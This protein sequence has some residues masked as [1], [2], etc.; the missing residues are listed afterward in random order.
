M[1]HSLQEGDVNGYCTITA[2][3]RIAATKINVASIVIGLIFMILRIFSLIPHGL[4]LCS[5]RAVARC[6]AL[7][8][9]TMNILRETDGA[10]GGRQPR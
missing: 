10:C 8:R 2:I 1:P 9:E 7:E 5:L 3:F 4:I 6:A